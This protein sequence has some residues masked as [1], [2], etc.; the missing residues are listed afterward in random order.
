[1]VKNTHSVIDA[2]DLSLVQ[3]CIYTAAANAWHA[4]TLHEA[5]LQARS[6]FTRP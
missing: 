5:D 4:R 6:V 1:M 2:A 3:E